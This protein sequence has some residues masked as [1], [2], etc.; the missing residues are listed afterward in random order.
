M[1][2]TY[3]SFVV[4]FE[5]NMAPMQSG[6]SSALSFSRLY[7]QDSANAFTS[8]FSSGLSNGFTNLSGTI[9]MLGNFKGQFASTAEGLSAIFGMKASADLEYY[10]R[11]LV[12]LTGDA[13]KANQMLSEMTKIANTTAFGNTDIFDMTTKIIG[14]GTSPD[15]AM[16]ETK[17]ILDAVT[18][19][20]TRNMAAFRRFAQNL[21]DLRLSPGE[22][23]KQQ[24]LQ[25]LRAA[26][27]MGKAAADALGVDQKEAMSRMLSMTGEELYGLFLSIGKRNEGKA[28]AEGM[29]DPFVGAENLAQTIGSATASTGKLVNAVITPLIGIGSNLVN[30]FGDIN[31]AGMGVPGLLIGLTLLRR[32]YIYH[33]T[34]IGRVNLALDRLAG[35]AN[36]AA[37]KTGASGM[38]GIGKASVVIESVIIAAAAA[39]AAGDWLASKNYSGYSSATPDDKVRLTETEARKYGM[40]GFNFTGKTGASNY[41]DTDKDPVASDTK[42]AAKDIKEA[43]KMLKDA[44]ADGY[45]YG[46][47]GKAAMSSIEAGYALVG[48]E[49]LGIA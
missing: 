16:G 17:N 39:Q 48:A 20:G 37:T 30:A 9:G 14:T 47:R 28:A 26:P 22:P 19:S 45:G 12:M 8:A 21:T 18:A 33:M 3:A 23:E 25:S 10:R 44:T 24:V 6:M 41:A 2:Q 32:A 35:S 42:S 31:Q 15:A 38:S 36:H 13:G 4:D 11:Q 7:G 46:K 43:A 40:A 49:R 34:Q 29:A 1:S 27:N 5:A